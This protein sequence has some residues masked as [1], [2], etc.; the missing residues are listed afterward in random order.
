MEIVESQKTMNGR[1]Q[2]LLSSQEKQVSSKD[3]QQKSG[4]HARTGKGIVSAI[5]NTPLIEIES[6]SAETGCKIVVKLENLNP[7]GSVKDRAALWIVNDAEKQGLLKKDGYICEGSG[8]NTGVALSLIAAAKGYK[9]FIAIP[10]QAS[11]EKVAMIKAFGA[12]T[13]VCPMVPF[14]DSRNYF[15]VASAFAKAHPNS[16]FTNQFDNKAN[17]LSH[18]EGTAPEIWEQTQHQLDGFVCAAGT[19]G[20]I[21]GCS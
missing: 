13:E 15:H 18:Y 16:I 17:F 19:G 6:L 4:L 3:Q 14:T 20:T 8:G 9:A 10:Q 7:G 11:D 1:L 5:G 12:L 2:E 21:S